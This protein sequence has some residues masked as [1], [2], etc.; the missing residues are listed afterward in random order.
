MVCSEAN[1]NERSS[2]E[3]SGAPLSSPAMGTAWLTTRRFATAY[4]EPVLMRLTGMEGG[5]SARSLGG[6]ASTSSCV[7]SLIIQPCCQ[8]L[9]GDEPACRIDAGTHV[10]EMG[11]AV[12]VPAELV[13]AH[14]LHAHRLADGLRHHRRRLRGIVVAAAAEGAGTLAI[15]HPHLLD[16]QGQHRREHGARVVDI[17]RGANHQ[18]AVRPDVGERAVRGE[19]CVRLIGAAVGRPRRMR[20]ACEG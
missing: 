8:I 15:L 12:V 4:M 16:R 10:S 17:L 2:G 9:V 13:P 11:R 20:R 5:P 3:R 14:E 6:V 18:C 1:A 19:R 7:V